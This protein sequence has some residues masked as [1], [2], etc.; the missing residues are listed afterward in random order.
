[1]NPLEGN[2]WLILIAVICYFIGSFPTAYF[3]TRAMIGKD[4]RLAGSRNVG[5]MNAYG[6]IKAQHSEKRAAS[7]L[8]IIL[9]GDMA[10]GILAIYLSRWLG[11]L[12]YSPLPALIIASFFIIL[13]HNYPICFKFKEGGI[14]FASMLGI[15]LALNPYSLGV[16]GGTMLFCIFLGDYIMTR[17]RNV[18]S[19]ST[20]IGVIGKHIP[21]RLIGLG[22]AL[23][24][25]Y[26][27]ESRLV[28]PVLGPTVL[29]LIKHYARRKQ[30]PT[31]S[32]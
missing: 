12:G 30:L 19:L 24:P 15:L 21:G 20:A 13:G 11:F 8:V 2:L 27:L 28:F 23:I 32:N 14:G 9:F 7:G 3:A 1:M 5:G 31:N 4:I 10:K 16:W 22:I 6:L 26:F 18:H 17:K 29:I 25:I